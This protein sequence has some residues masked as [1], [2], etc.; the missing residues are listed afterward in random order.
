MYRCLS[1][2]LLLLAACLLPAS[3]WSQQFTAVSD[4]SLS[5]PSIGIALGGGGAR[6]LAH[7][8][9][10]ERLDELCIPIDHVAGTSIGAVVGALFS[11]GFAPEE[12]DQDLLGINWRH[13]MTDRP[14][15]RRLSYRRKSDDGRSSGP[16]SSASPGTASACSAV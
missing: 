15:R 3:A 16:S 14:D 9:V 11:L 4:T 13:L 6:G 1:V 10:L 7:I 2:L 8:G 5:R 12:I